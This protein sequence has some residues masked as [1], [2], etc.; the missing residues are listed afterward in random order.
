MNYSYYYSS[1]NYYGSYSSIYSVPNLS[2]YLLISSKSGKAYF[3]LSK[4]ALS[5]SFI[6][7]IFYTADTNN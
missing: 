2:K 7:N 5:A 6:S 3:K 1:V 4:S